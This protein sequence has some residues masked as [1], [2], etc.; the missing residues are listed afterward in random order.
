MRY[1]F[2]ILLMVVNIS[3]GFAVARS[4]APEPILPTTL[5]WGSP[6]DMPGVQ[7]AWVLGNEKKPGLYIMR[8]KLAAGARILPHTH[9]DDRHTTVLTGTIY[10]GFGESFD[11]AKVVAVPTGAVYIAPANV[12]HYVW[13]KVGEAMYQESGVGP[14]GTSFIER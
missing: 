3:S 4:L 14:T 13:G 11:V 2:A 1:F 5:H 8:V 7:G 10:V 9:P 12:P 6:P